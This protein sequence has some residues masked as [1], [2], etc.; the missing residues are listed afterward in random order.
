[1]T[2]DGVDPDV[3]LFAQLVRE[4]EAA[5]RAAVQEQRRQREEAERV[6]QAQTAKDAAAR[7]LKDLRAKGAPSTAIAEAEAAYR[8]TLAEVVTA[9][10]GARPDW[11]PAPYVGPRAD[12]DAGGNAGADAEAEAD[13]EDAEP[14]PVDAA[15]GVES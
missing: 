3:A 1:M 14:A 12:A 4:E 13:A 6:A 5:K 2:G 8:A 15:G 7:R 10:S 11:A 9:E